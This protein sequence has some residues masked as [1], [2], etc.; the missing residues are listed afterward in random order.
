MRLFDPTRDYYQALG[1][2]QRANAEQIKRAY[3]VRAR[4]CHPD[5]GGSPAAMRD[6]NEAYEVLRDKATRKAYDSER[7]F[8]DADH[9]LPEPKREAPLHTESL[10]IRR[11]DRDLLWLTTRGIICALLA[12]FWLLVVEDASPHRGKTVVL[13]WLFRGLSVVTLGIAILFG[14]SAHR[15]SQQRMSHKHPSRPEKHS[16]MCKF[17]FRAVIAGSFGLLILSLYLSK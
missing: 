9:S 12:L 5:L 11:P 15:R 10:G 6:L 16:S 13:P 14:Y 7:G 1:V 4:T 17:I 3:H 8:R 2:N